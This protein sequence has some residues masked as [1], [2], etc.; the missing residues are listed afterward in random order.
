MPLRVLLLVAFSL[1]FFAACATLAPPPAEPP[2]ETPDTPP[3]TVMPDSS[4]AEPTPSEPMPETPREEENEMPE[5]TT[6]EIAEADSLAAPDPLYEATE[7]ALRLAFTDGMFGL[8]RA[9]ADPATAQRLDRNGIRAWLTDLAL[10]SPRAVEFARATLGPVLEQR[11]VVG[12]LLENA[13]QVECAS[14]RD[15]LYVPVP[16]RFQG[17]DRAFTGYIVQ[18]ACDISTGDLAPFCAGGYGT[19]DSGMSCTCTCT[20]GEAP[21]QPCVSC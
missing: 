12:F 11:F 10:V 5:E 17:P 1:A 20:T 18:D 2:T 14:V 19:T 6:E 15:V 16:E 21:A 4:A 9:E 8:Y 7:E 13:A 3:P